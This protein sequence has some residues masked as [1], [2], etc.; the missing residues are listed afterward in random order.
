MSWP[1]P[2][3]FNEAVQNPA[4][5]FSDP[6]LQAGEIVTGP[7]GL[8]LPHSGNF[9]DV[10]QVRGA[11]GR[12]WAVKCF[13]RPVSGLAQRYAQVSATL[14]EANLPFTIS[15][16]FLANG[17]R[18]RGDWRP[19][20]KMEWVEGTLL[21]LVAQQNADRPSVLIALCQMWPKLCR[22]LREARFAHAD[23]QHGNV[24]LV[25]GSRVGA[26]GLKLIDYDGMYL[27]TLSHMPSGESG[28]P[29]FQHPARAATGAYSADLDRFPYL[30]VATALKALTAHGS[31]LWQ[32][33]DTGDNLLFV[34]SDF[35]RPE[36][37]P[38]MQEL[39]ASD[40]PDVR[41]LVGRL[42]LACSRGI[43][44]TPWLD[45]IVWD[46]EVAPLEQAET[47]DIAALLGS[48]VSVSLAIQSPPPE[49]P[50]VANPDDSELPRPVG[51]VRWPEP[52][53]RP[54]AKTRKTSAQRRSTRSGWKQHGRLALVALAAIL[55]VG[56]AVCGALF[57]ATKKPAITPTQDESVGMG[58][59]DSTP[60]R[61]KEISSKEDNTP[62]PPLK[63][64]SRRKVA[65][66]E[67]EEPKDPYRKGTIWMGH[68]RWNGDPGYHSYI[69]VFTERSKS[70]FKGFAYLDYGPSGNPKRIGYYTVEGEVTGQGF[71]YKGDLGGLNEVQAKPMNDGIQIHA[72]A[73]NGGRLSG[74]LHP[75]DPRN[76]KRET[77]AKI[78]NA[79]IMLLLAAGE[80]EEVL[81]AYDRLAGLQP[82]ESASIKAQQEKL[83]DEWKP[84]GE[85]H[86]RARDYL[87]KTWPALATVEELNDSLPWLRT[88]IDVCKKAADKYAIRH[89]RA[90]LRRFPSELSELIKDM[91]T[92]SDA[93]TKT[94]EQVQEINQ[95]V[96]PLENEI[97]EFL[98]AN[99]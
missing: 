32:R 30:V 90:T 67:P 99:P 12:D 66:P 76:I 5:V 25:P 39:W 31:P 15:F 43:A 48:S 22:R 41:R 34:D 72:T 81:A 52:V 9:A 42:A 94:F 84:R 51:P 18:V 98:R 86:A 57:L 47:R 92:A 95:F 3:D 93:G 59:D 78:L 71:K 24:I 62:P 96:V 80:V 56:A 46:G 61:S 87:R 60:P 45:D 55:I 74:I 82:T 11:D 27:P 35:Q 54:K 2:Q 21:N 10:Y 49:K 53:R 38:L 65:T 40:N 69:L 19:V 4:A 26:Y 33:Y 44:E 73:A 77:Q 79:R 83:A 85:E 64:I 6:D 91:S 14:A 29:N 37:S 75:H 1:L 7:H 17:I 50:L 20:I 28:H 63:E 58:K 8:P 88:A 70:K 13:T 68:L 23:L 36:A 89:L 16:K 97:A